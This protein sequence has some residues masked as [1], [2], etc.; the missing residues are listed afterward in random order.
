MNCFQKS[1]RLAFPEEDNASLKKIPKLKDPVENSRLGL[2]VSHWANAHHFSDN[3]PFLD[4]YQISCFCHCLQPRRADLDM[5]QHVNN[6]TYIG[7]VLEVS[8]Y[9]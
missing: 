5:N 1:C 8:K 7:W 4:G 2:T 6:V 9:H 3:I